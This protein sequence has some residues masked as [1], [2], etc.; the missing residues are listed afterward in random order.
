MTSSAPVCPV[1]KEQQPLQEYQ[2]LQESWFFRW[3]MLAPLKYIRLSLILWGI[4]CIISAPIASVS[5]PA[6][7]DPVHFAL[8]AAAGAALLPLL[9]LFR[10]YLGWFYIRNRLHDETVVYEE[11]GWYDGQIWEK[12]AE[13]VQRD[14]LIVVYQIHPILNRLQYSLLAVLLWFVIGGVIWRLVDIISH[15]L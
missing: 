14:R 1:P 7:K 3:A 2:A 5:F 9:V 11:S 10:L 8:S 12:P 4:G 6:A 15:S 13:V